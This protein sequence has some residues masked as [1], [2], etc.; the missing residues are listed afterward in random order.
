MAKNPLEE[1]LKKGGRDNPSYDPSQQAL[2]PSVSRGGDYFVPVQETPKTNAALNFAKELSR[3]P[4]VYKQAVDMNQERAARE[5]AEM[6][7]E[8]FNAHYNELLSQD[9]E[10]QS[11]FGYNK[12]FQEKLVERTYKDV[13]PLELKELEKEFKGTLQNYDSID[14]YDNAVNNKVNEYFDSLNSRFNGNEFASNAH[15]ALAVGQKAKLIVNLHDAY[16]EETTKYIREEEIDTGS[17]TL[18]KLDGEYDALGTTLTE[19]NIA[20]ANNLGDKKTANETT[21]ST[22]AAHLDSLI[23][24]STT[25]GLENAEELFNEV[26]TNDEPLLVNGKDIFE[27]SEGQ[28]METEYRVKL[29][30]ARLALPQ[31]LDAKYDKIENEYTARIIRAQGNQEELDA[32]FAELDAEI[33][34]EGDDGLTVRLNKYK[35]TIKR[36]PSIFIDVAVNDFVKSVPKNT[37]HKFNDNVTFTLINSED[38]NFTQREM[39]LFFKRQ[40]GGTGDLVGTELAM[41]LS[42][43]HQ[44]TYN[45]LVREKLQEIYLNP[46]LSDVEREQQAQ[47]ALQEA[48][49]ESNEAVKREMKRL[50]KVNEPKLEAQS[51]EQLAINAGA[52]EIELNRVRNITDPI[53]QIQE[54]NRLAEESV[55]QDDPY[56][57]T[58][59]KVQI[60][61]NK[62]ESVATTLDNYAQVLKLGFN[63][64]ESALE[65]HYAVMEQLERKG[66]KYLD[67]IGQQYANGGENQALDALWQYKELVGFTKEELDNGYVS[68]DYVVDTSSVYSPYGIVT[69]SNRVQ[70][71]EIPLEKI[72]ARDT[73]GKDPRMA[74]E[75]D[76]AIIIDGDIANTIYALKEGNV[77]AFLPPSTTGGVLDDF[78]A[79]TKEAQ[80]IYDAQRRYFV[81]MGYLEAGEMFDGDDDLDPDPEKKTL[82]DN[83]VEAIDSNITENFGKYSIGNEPTNVH[84]QVIDKYNLR[85]ERGKTFINYKD[86]AKKFYTSRLPNANPEAIDR[87]V[88]AKFKLLE[89]R[90]PELLNTKNNEVRIVFK[91][92]GDRIG[93]LAYRNKDLIEVSDR[94]RNIE[95]VEQTIMHELVHASQKNRKGKMTNLMTNELISKGDYTSPDKSYMD[96]LTSP[97]ETDARLAEVAR[98]WVLKGNEFIDPRKGTEVAEDALVDFLAHRNNDEFDGT[99]VQ[100]IRM[101][102]FPD[103]YIVPSNQ[104]KDL[105]NKERAKW[106]GRGY[107]DE[108]RIPMEKEDVGEEWEEKVRQEL[109]KNPNLK[110]ILE[111]IGT[112]VQNESTQNPNEQLA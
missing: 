65:A 60:K 18:E 58:D 78:E 17:R 1:L 51:A 53:L 59:G 5:I 95:A 80:R 81:A 87:I 57:I 40:D 106:L 103:S 21:R 33:Q 92:L 70:T 112:L 37:A 26:F 72:W 13:V 32:I 7:D 41:E 108:S 19:L 22:V 15:N 109:R 75:E 79:R 34:Q 66:V 85:T 96:Y 98:R 104:V 10:L 63:D 54:F 43:Y 4:E 45:Q 46:N 97:S 62:N 38:I 91:D 35:D 105:P 12:A 76:Y 84:E 110:L 67:A 44:K 31:L 36:D 20:T 14:D 2:N 48:Y 50:T 27:G 101:L 55:K 100:L 30:N 52:N 90:S 71:I 77:S 23:A 49:E 64:R 86:F 56:T 102:G 99:R 83:E 111:S 93:G 28:K 24:L 29:H 8:E 89:Q 9:K 69:P 39:E 3:T 42:G 107:T 68:I 16:I 47:E 61:I 94:Y 82:E 25:E 11:L 88:D 6:S 74:S 73:I